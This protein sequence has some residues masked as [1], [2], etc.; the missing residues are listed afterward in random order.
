MFCTFTVIP[1]ASIPAVAIAASKATAANKRSFASFAFT[2]PPVSSRNIPMILLYQT[3]LSSGSWSLI[4]R[5]LSVKKM[6]SV[7]V[8]LARL[9]KLVMTAPFSLTSYR[10][11]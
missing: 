11:T 10:L 9:V 5:S 2:S 3:Y 8:S 1:N 7:T 6:S 4:S